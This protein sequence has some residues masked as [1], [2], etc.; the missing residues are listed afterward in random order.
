MLISYFQNYFNNNQI[1]YLDSF[2][3]KKTCLLEMP[4]AI[5]NYINKNYTVNYL[6]SAKHCYLNKLSYEEIEKDKDIK[7]AIFFIRSDDKFLLYKKDV[8]EVDTGWI[9]SNKVKSIEIIKLGEF[10][11]LVV[12]KV[13][14]RQQ[15]YNSEKN[16]RKMINNK[17][18]NTIINKILTTKRVPKNRFKMFLNYLKR[19]QEKYKN[20][21]DIKKM[22]TYIISKKKVLIH[23]VPQVFLN[24]ELNEVI[25][26]ID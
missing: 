4:S 24:N 19:N 8:K 20:D 25:K 10:N 17:N 15:R 14:G 1:T 6:I 13:F 3:N 2:R 16:Y 26:K 21:E 22:V 9:W 12:N 18:Y 5:F 11:S 23:S 7:N